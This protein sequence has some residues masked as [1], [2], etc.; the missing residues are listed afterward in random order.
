MEEAG[1]VAGDA[2]AVCGREPVVGAVEWSGVVLIGATAVSDVFV[3]VVDLDA[4][5]V[6]A[7]PPGARGAEEPDHVA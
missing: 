3:E 5:S 7:P 6:V 4:E 1:V 2:V